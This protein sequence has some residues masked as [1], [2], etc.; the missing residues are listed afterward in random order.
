[1]PDNSVS[2]KAIIANNLPTL[3]YL[4]SLPT[5]TANPLAALKLSACLCR[6]L[7]FSCLLARSP[8]LTNALN[9]EDLLPS[10]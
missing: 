10:A 9:M 1:M 3:I 7:A 8:N 6:L 2:R 4:A 5:S